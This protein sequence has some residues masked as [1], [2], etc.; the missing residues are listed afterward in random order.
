MV[1]GLHSLGAF[2]SAAALVVL[3]PGPATLLVAGQA[4][5]SG[6]RAARATAGVV[7]GDLVLITLSG[8]GFAAV[9]QQWPA[10]GQALTVAGALYVAWLGLGLLRSA[11][12]SSGACAADT[13][14]AGFL[15]GLMLTLTNPKPVLFFGAFFPLFID[16]AGGRWMTSFYA[17][18]AIFEVINLV[19]FGVLI[20]LV[21]RLRRVA[22]LGGV[23]RGRIH[24]LSGVGLLLCAVA[25]LA[26]TPRSA[27][28]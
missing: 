4:H 26:T 19:Y 1:D 25:M 27:W 2:V 9:M 12:A 20:L 28:A 13:P 18:G 16:R 24:Q 10:L 5:R 6:W 8:L 21:T 11:P 15:Q 22:A 7:A 3:V 17:L 14:R 23:P